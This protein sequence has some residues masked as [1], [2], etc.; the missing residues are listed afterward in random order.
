MHDCTDDL[1]D[2]CTDDLWD[3]GPDDLWDDYTDDP[4]NHDADTHTHSEM[5][6]TP[7]YINSKA[8]MCWC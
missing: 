7:L 6:Y 3:D 5:P 2:G 1:W 4:W 8:V